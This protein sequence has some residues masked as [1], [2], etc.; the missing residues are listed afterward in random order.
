MASGTNIKN[1]LGLQLRVESRIPPLLNGKSDRHWQWSNLSAV[2]AWGSYKEHSDNP[3]LAIKASLGK[4]VFGRRKSLGHWHMDT[5]VTR[6]PLGVALSLVFWIP[7]ECHLY[8]LPPQAGSAFSLASHAHL[9]SDVTASTLNWNKTIMDTKNKSTHCNLL[10]SILRDSKRSICFHL[11]WPPVLD[12]ANWCS[13]NCSLTLWSYFGYQD[14]LSCPRLPDELW[15]IGRGSSGI[16]T[17]EAK[18]VDA[19]PSS[20][21][22]SHSTFRPMK[23]YVYAK[24]SEAVLHCITQQVFTGCISWVQHVPTKNPLPYK[25]DLMELS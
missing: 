1:H 21:E 4:W 2:S 22:N 8:L 9:L 6:Q 3:H 13:Q 10:P 15:E 24:H 20:N 5:L 11:N 23:T 12:V 18:S 7:C 19:R 14:I 17:R 16:K 25:K